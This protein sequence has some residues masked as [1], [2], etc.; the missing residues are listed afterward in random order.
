M[1]NAKLLP[2]R[3][4]KCQL[5]L[6]YFER[7]HV[8]KREWASIPKNQI[9]LRF[10]LSRESSGR[11]THINVPACLLSILCLLEYLTEQSGLHAH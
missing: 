1:N 8:K 5:G 11:F 2:R 3:K 9:E 10:A 6:L 7:F 4:F